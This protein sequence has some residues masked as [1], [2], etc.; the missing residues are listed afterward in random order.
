M[1]MTIRDE[2]NVTVT[3]LVNWIVPQL[4]ILQYTY[5]LALPGMP[6][7]SLTLYTTTNGTLYT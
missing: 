3:N 1:L 6:I 2:P 4:T 7:E 5:L